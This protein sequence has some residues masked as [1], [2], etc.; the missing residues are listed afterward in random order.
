VVE[1]GLYFLEARCARTGTRVVRELAA[2]L[3]EIEADA[4]QL[5]QVLVNLVVNAV[6]A[7]PEGGTL[8]VG[9]RAA[10]AAVVLWVA[11]TGT[12]IPDEILGKIFLP[13][14]STK[15]VTEGTGLGLSVVHGI[16]TAHGG[17]ID[18]QSR[19]GQGT[20]FEICL[21]AVRSGADQENGAN[22]ASR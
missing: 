21:P 22:A 11:D 7:M 6:Q 10:D 15:D 9:T 4:A 8:T 5:K 18:V 14:F 12:G 1:E 19:P 16:I 17:S 20:R 2:A 13:F 3:P